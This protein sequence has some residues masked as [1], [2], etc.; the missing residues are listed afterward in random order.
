MNL[1]TIRM[2][3][4]VWQMPFKKRS[5]AALCSLLPKGPRRIQKFHG[6]KAMK[7]DAKGGPKV[8]ATPL[9]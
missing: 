2:K 6:I 8:I 3:Y 1:I 5:S 7:A 4:Q 9:L